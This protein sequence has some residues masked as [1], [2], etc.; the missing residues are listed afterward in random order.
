MASDG[1]QAVT[2]SAPK[3]RS[4]AARTGFAAA[5]SV[6]VTGDRDSTVSSG[7][8]GQ[9][10]PAHTDSA[11][12][13]TACSARPSPAAEKLRRLTSRVAASGSTLPRSPAC[14]EPTDTASP[15]D[16]PSSSRSRSTIS[17]ATTIGF[18]ARCG[19]A[20]W[21]PRPGT[22]SRTVLLPASTAPVPCATIPAGSGA[23]CWAST[24]SGTPT[25]S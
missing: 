13:R 14:S 11:M 8:A 19:T 3:A 12:P 15:A 20:G 21:P 4:C 9:P 10:A 2:R 5:G 6:T 18:T 24:T 23:V 7:P 16:R 1:G 22:A 17:A 25:R